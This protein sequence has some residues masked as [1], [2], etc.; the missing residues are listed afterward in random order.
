MENFDW[1]SLQSKY[2]DILELFKEEYPRKQRFVVRHFEFASF[3]LS[4]DPK[5]AKSVGSNEIHFSRGCGS[6]KEA[7]SLFGFTGF[8]SSYK[9]I[10]V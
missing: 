4:L 8:V 6:K 2:S 1:Q 5:F 9:K 3:H 10:C 7:V